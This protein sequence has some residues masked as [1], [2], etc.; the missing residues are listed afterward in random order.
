MIKYYTDWHDVDEDKTTMTNYGGFWSRDN[1][2]G[3]MIR[4]LYQ[5][6]DY[7]PGT[8]DTHVASSD[9]QKYRIIRILMMS[10]KTRR[11]CRLKVG[12]GFGKV[13]E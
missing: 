13:Q 11:P 5:S 3:V 6:P 9:T 8:V 1:D 7:D 4:D 10:T 12:I 2:V